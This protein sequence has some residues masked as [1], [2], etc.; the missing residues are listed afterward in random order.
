MKRKNGIAVRKNLDDIFREFQGIPK[1]LE[2]D[3]VG[4]KIFRT[5]ENLS[6]GWSGFWK[7]RQI[8][9]LQKGGEFISDK[10]RDFF[11]KRKIVF[12]RKY[13]ITKA[14]RGTRLAA[15]LKICP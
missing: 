6:A 9:G 10:S 4:P 1:V 5:F 13:G 11:K 15:S 7:K 14:F 12:H 3:Q 8:F 2:S